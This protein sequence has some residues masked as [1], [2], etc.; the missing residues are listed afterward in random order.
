MFANDF[1]AAFVTAVRI[2]VVHADVVGAERTVIIGVRLMV[3]QGIEFV[4][5]L[6]PTGVEDSQQQFVL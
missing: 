3:G 5:H 2:I 1:A 4:E 6:S